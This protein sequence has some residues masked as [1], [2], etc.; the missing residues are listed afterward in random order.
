MSS[1]QW[2]PDLLGVSGG[3]LSRSIFNAKQNITVSC[4]DNVNWRTSLLAVVCVTQHQGAS[5]LLPRTSLPCRQ[6]EEL[7]TKRPTG[8]LMLVLSSPFS[9]LSLW[10]RMFMDEDDKF[11]DEDARWR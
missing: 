2:K 5:T 9:G 7:I 8:K 6:S 3:S 11:M 4:L 10:M 1:L